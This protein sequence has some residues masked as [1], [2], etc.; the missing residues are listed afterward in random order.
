MYLK[1]VCRWLFDNDDVQKRFVWRGDRRE[2]DEKEGI[3]MESERQKAKT[4]KQKWSKCESKK[5]KKRAK[6]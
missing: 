6:D 3:I 1:Y 2:K 4:W 5:N